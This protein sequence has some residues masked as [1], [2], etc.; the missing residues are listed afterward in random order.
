M[1]EMPGQQADSTSAVNSAMIQDLAD[2]SEI[3]DLFYAYAQ[4][5]DTRN[6]ELFRSLFTDVV[7]L[8]FSAVNGR[9]PAP[10]PRDSWISYLAGLFGALDASQHVITNPRITVRENQATAMAYVRG[11]HV[12][13]MPEEQLLY[14][15]G[16]FYTNTAVRAADGWRWNAVAITVL[17][18]AG[19]K[20]AMDIARTRSAAAPGISESA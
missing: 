12:L 5:V 20:R 6:W 19:D 4:G 14:T 18:D 16:G 15:V 11:E 7:L 1:T 10:T 8:D 3:T 13:R 2:R 9:Q 17:W